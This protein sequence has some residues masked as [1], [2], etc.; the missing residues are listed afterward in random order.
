M[1]GHGDVKCCTRLGKVETN[2]LIF[3]YN[4][5]ETFIVHVLYKFSGYVLPV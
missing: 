1:E 5:W 4:S 2:Y 3:L